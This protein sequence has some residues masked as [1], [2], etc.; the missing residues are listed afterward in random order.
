MSMINRRLVVTINRRLLNLKECAYLD[1]DILTIVTHKLKSQ[2]HVLSFSKWPRNII[3]FVSLLIYEG[4]GK[5]DRILNNWP[6]GIRASGL[7]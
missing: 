6:S 5:Y 4:G 7:L 1:K 3:L 2:C